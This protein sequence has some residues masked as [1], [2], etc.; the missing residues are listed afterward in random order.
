LTLPEIYKDKS[1]LWN[2]WSEATTAIMGH[3]DENEKVDSESGW[4]F[5]E[6][7]VHQSVGKD[8]GYSVTV[9]STAYDKTKGKQLFLSVQASVESSDKITISTV[10]RCEVDENIKKIL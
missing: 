9:F 10:K 5:R 7:T 6:G 1:E 8:S 3:I 2:L 4:S